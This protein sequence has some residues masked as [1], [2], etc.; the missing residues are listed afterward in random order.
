MS[1]AHSHVNRRDSSSRAKTV[2]PGL[3]DSQTI[4]L[5]KDKS[6]VE[7][8]M[9]EIDSRSPSYKGRGK[10][11]NPKQNAHKAKDREKK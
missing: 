6:S 10:H 1:S 5:I 2:T 9:L 11:D 8:N 4:A 7:D 3:G